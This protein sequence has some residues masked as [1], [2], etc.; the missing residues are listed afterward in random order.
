LR[1]QRQVRSSS[2]SEATANSITSNCRFRLV[3]LR[4]DADAGARDRLAG[5]RAARVIL[6]L[7]DL[8]VG[9]GHGWGRASGFWTYRY[10]HAMSV[11]KY[12]SNTIGT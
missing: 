6:V 2:S 1:A 9:R 3:V 10:V 8:Q 12:T 11:S 5:G 4:A 7:G